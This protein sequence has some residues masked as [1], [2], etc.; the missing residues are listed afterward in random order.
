[1]CSKDPVVALSI[2]PSDSEMENIL[3]LLV[4]THDS[5]VSVL[6][7]DTSWVRAAAA[8][9]HPALAPAR[10]RVFPLRGHFISGGPLRPSSACPQRPSHLAL[11]IETQQQNCGRPARAPVYSHLLASTFCSPPPPPSLPQKSASPFCS[12]CAFS[13]IFP[14]V[15]DSISS[16]RAFFFFI[17]ALLFAFSFHPQHLLKRH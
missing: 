13:G 6:V 14:A 15:A 17:P 2:R 9:A 16:V 7:V 3:Q 1:M 4:I 11:G 8:C 5:P 12:R 10:V